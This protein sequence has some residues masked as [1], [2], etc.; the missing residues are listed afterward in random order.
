M[1][2]RIATPTYKEQQTKVGG[3]LGYSVKYG[4]EGLAG[5]QVQ[6]DARA[7]S[8]RTSGA[9]AALGSQQCA[10]KKTGGPTQS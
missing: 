6:D 10:K 9:V 5:G 4:N 8:G 1:R 3:K 2:R 7:L